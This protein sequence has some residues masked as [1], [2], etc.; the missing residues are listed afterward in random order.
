MLYEFRKGDFVQ[1][2]NASELLQDNRS[3]SPHCA[4]TCYSGTIAEVLDDGVRH[5]LR[6]LDLV[7][8]FNPDDYS[9]CKFVDVLWHNQSLKPCEWLDPCDEGFDEVFI[10]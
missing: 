8:H 7:I 10:A 2:K 9:V 4:I 3:C 1:I 6:P 5:H